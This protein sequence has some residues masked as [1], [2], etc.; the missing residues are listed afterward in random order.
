MSA[1]D[2]YYIRHDT[3]EH[4][5]NFPWHIYRGADYP[6]GKLLEITVTRRGALRIIRRD[7]RKK[8]HD[9]FVTE[10]ITEGTRQL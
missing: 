6:R 10:V 1:E 2:R 3:D 7:Q 4:W 5:Y 8:P 9:Q